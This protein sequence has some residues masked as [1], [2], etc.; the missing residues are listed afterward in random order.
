MENNNQKF[1]TKCGSPL[2]LEATF[3][4]FCGTQCNGQS[5]QEPTPQEPTPTQQYNMNIESPKAGISSKVDIEKTIISNIIP[6]GCLI[7]GIVLFF[8]GLGTRVPRTYINSYVMNEYVG[9]DA[10]NFIIEA[11]LRGGQIAGA[12]ASK[13][14]YIAVG[15]LIACLSALKIHV[16]KSEHQ[17]E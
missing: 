2:A 17:G 4:S 6:V 12:C 7:I 11:S 16:V 13:A 15:L 8:V 10:Y 1:C 3:C 14:I 5:T 9:G